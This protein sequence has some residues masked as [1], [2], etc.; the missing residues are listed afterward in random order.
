V[1]ILFSITVVLLY[2]A[3]VVA[4]AWSLLRKRREAAEVGRGFM[5]AAV[6]AGMVV[7]PL[8][9]AVGTIVALAQTQAPLAVLTPICVL[10]AALFGGGVLLESA[11]SSEL[12]LPLRLIGWSLLAGVALIP[13]FLVFL[14]PIPTVLAFFV[15]RL[16]ENDSPKRRTNPAVRNS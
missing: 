13:S 2:S 15:P 10:G 14:L 7:L 9:S 8:A 4:T 1:F 11:F 3:F 12:A 5:L 6:A 16:L